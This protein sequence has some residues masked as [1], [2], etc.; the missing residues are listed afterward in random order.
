M[1]ELFSRFAPRIEELPNRDLL[2]KNDLLVS[3]FLLLKENRIEIY[4][5]PFDF[6]N[7]SAKIVLIG[8]TPGWKQFLDLRRCLLGFPHPSG[9]NRQ[10]ARQYT[11]MQANLKRTVATWLEKQ[12]DS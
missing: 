3:T 2:T 10:R 5:A 8:I 12:S 7:E 9:A 1:N 11:S 6:V 4:Y